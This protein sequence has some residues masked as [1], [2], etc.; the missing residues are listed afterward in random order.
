M[1]KVM[2]SK[3]YGMFRVSEFQRDIRKTK[4]LEDSM[5]K[6]GWIDSK[7]MDVMRNGGRQF[8]IRDG[9]HRFEVA[10]RLGIPVK[11][12]VDDSKIT[13]AE[14]EETTE[15]WKLVDFMTHN[16]RKGKEEYIKVKRYQAETGIP[17][18]NV[19]S[20]LGG[21]AASSGNMSKVFKDGDFVVKGT[22]HAETVKDIVLCLKKNGI[23]FASTE[24]FVRA[25]SKAVFVP[26]FDPEHLKQKIKL[27][28]SFIEKQA[29]VDQ[30]LDMIEDIYNRQ[31]RVK[32]PLKFMANEEAKR[33]NAVKKPRR[34][35]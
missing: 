6:H 12:V 9:H 20:M 24:L 13:M 25:I 30:Y 11:F 23:S 4:A 22:R 34:P 8:I 19:I 16:V 2:Q 32:I 31:S 26:K 28:H 10:R 15:S 3:D 17:L 1:I 18:T 29:T 14:I 21:H 33:R 27:F 35:A 7:P 5:R